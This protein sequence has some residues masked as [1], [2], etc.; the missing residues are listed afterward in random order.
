MK[1]GVKITL[2]AVVAAVGLTVVV[3]ESFMSLNTLTYSINHIREYEMPNANHASTMLTNIHIMARQ[4]ASMIGGDPA[5]KERR[6]NSHRAAF[7]KIQNAVNDFSKTAQTERGRL[8]L[9]SASRII[10]NEFPKRIAQFEAAIIAEDHALAKEIRDCDSADSYINCIYRITSISE[11]AHESVMTMQDGFLNES[12]N[13]AEDARRTLVIT[14]IIAAI[15]LV[16]ISM[17][18]IVGITRPLKRA[19]T[20]TTQISEGNF[21]V[22]LTSNSKDETGIL[23][24]ELTGVVQTVRNVV[25][26]VNTL[27]KDVAAEGNFEARLEANK[28]KGSYRQLAQG[29]NKMIEDVTL[30]FEHTS[31]YLA[32][33]AKGDIPAKITTQEKGEFAV[34][35]DNLNQCFDALRLIVT[36]INSSIEKAKAGDLKYRANVTKHQGD[37]RSIMEGVNQLVEAFVLPLQETARFI[38]DVETGNPEMKPITAELK[39]D[40]NIIKNHVNSLHSFLYHFLGEL[41]KV[42]ERARDGDL[43]VRAD[44]S[45]AKGTWDL[46]ETAVNDI[47]AESEKIVNDV[48]KTMKIMATGDLTPRITA[49]YKGQFAVVK[50]DIN[51]LGDSLT[52]LI[53][54]LQ[55]AIHT[56]ATAS[57]EI[58]A[59]ADTLAAATH[60]QNSQTDEVASAMEKMARTVTENASS[61]IRTADVAKSSGEVANNGSKVVSQTVNK[62]R[63]IAG[64]VKHSADN[65]AKLGDS[66]K[67]IGEI[68]GV[69]D[70]IADQ[71][72]LLS[73]NA[74][75]EAARAGEQGRGFAVV[76]DSVGKLAVSTA[77][78]TKEIAGMIK[79]IQT[80]TEAAV[81]AMEKGTSEVQSGIELADNAGNSL[82]NILTGINE[83]L[84]M[85]NQIAAASEQQS[86]TSEQI[87]KNVTSISKVT[88]DSAKN[89]E[90]VASTA[91]ELARMTETLTTLVSQFKVNPSGG[92]AAL[93]GNNN[94]YLN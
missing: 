14:V 7:E 49:D 63:E 66:S 70:D 41:M 25:S 37:Y 22:D 11:V 36:D 71:T 60:E 74:A 10:A 68:I 88:A 40:F 77:S 8:L 80:D 48:A 47:V 84:S 62:M 26:D 94:R 86:A 83:L 16:V 59:T 72:N 38:E 54:Q 61:A 33:I 4:S 12:V 92:S 82:Q 1:I 30:P 28:Y 85:V 19:V 17:L 6:L 3:I 9:D 46:M 89:I 64:V 21:D 34:I 42:G 75:I 79:G 13:D 76:A 45:R 93:G 91:N 69:I 90:D 29:I 31:E 2:L 67:K 73:L 24:L 32:R 51:L 20:A 35:R 52:S 5:Y 58:S 44:K 39:G 53:S 56:T 18:V 27:A 43:S 55:E 81:K 65:I 87:S 15:V 78:A 50:N 23:M 57:A